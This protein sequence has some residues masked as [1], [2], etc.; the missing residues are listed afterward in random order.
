VAREM[1]RLT[2]AIVGR[3]LFD[4][5][6]ESHA[7]QVGRALTRVLETFWIT[8]LPFGQTIEKLPIPA[9]RDA[10]RA[11]ADLDAVIY[12]M[13]VDRRAEGRDHGDLLSMLLAARDTAEEGDGRGLSDRQVRDEAMT[14]MLAGHETT[15]NALTWTWYLLSQSPDAVAALED[16]LA[17]VLGG[18]LPTFDDLPALRYTEQVASEALRLYPPAW[19][20]GRRSID[21]YSVRGYTLPPRTVFMMSPWVVQ[22]D[23]RWFPEPERFRPERW[24]PEFKESLPRLAFFPFGAGAR[25]CIG[26]SFAWT[27]MTLLIATIAQRWRLAHVAGHRA[28]PQPLITL[29][30]RYGMMMTARAR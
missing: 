18:R 15:A 28:V 12:R 11:R 21:A 4:L 9:I 6:V 17:R 19:M 27:E 5:D 7:D 26:D 3:T 24:T 20:I 13:I 23:A 14:L 8:L 10:H 2:L 30:A 25:Q 16:E 29:R 1:N 22:R